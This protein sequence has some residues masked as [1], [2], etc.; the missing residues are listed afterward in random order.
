L[1]LPFKAPEETGKG[2]CKDP[3]LLQHVPGHV[4][5]WQLTAY[6]LLL[7]AH[8]SLLTAYCLLLTAPLIARCSLLTAYCSLLSAG[9]PCR[10]LFLF[11][12]HDLRFTAFLWSCLTLSVVDARALDNIQRNPQ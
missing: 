2:I 7:T 11:A 1:D 10:A 9:L 5:G 8:C 6:C 4:N 12:I 3:L